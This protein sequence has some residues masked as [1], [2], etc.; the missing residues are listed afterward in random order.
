MTSR[1]TLNEYEE[2]LIMAISFLKVRENAT[3]AEIRKAYKEA[4][5]K[6]HPDKNNNSSEST[7]AFQALGNEMEILIE[8]SKN[9]VNKADEK[10]NAA[11]TVPFYKIKEAKQTKEVSVT[12][13][14]P[15][16]TLRPD[17]DATGTDVIK[18]IFNLMNN[19][20]KYAKKDE[21]KSLKTEE[22]RPVGD[23][24]YKGEIPHTFTKTIEIENAEKQK[25]EKSQVST[26]PTPLSIK[27]T[28][29]KGK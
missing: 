17:S 21:T 29:G 3:E 19:F 12:V 9:P 6:Y 1:L 7:A 15:T 2:Y 16:F 14:Y 25:V 26:A 27:Y 10:V 13:H 8:K 4:A 18:G 20:G 5:L 28:F 23:L 22:G 24:T 11:A